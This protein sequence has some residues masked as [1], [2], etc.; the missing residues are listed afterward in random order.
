MKKIYLIIFAM[1]PLLFTSCLKSNLDEIQVYQEANITSI[2]GMYYY[3]DLKT[4]N[5]GNTIF[6]KAD[7]SRADVQIDT[8][9]GNI[10]IGRATPAKANIASF[11]PQKVVMAFNISTAA[12]IEPVE[13][14]AQL[15]VESDWS[16]GKTNKYKVTAADGSSK[17]WSVTVLS[18]ITE[19]E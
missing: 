3:F 11:S 16:V 12:T 4:T 15:G 17:I 10:V 13:G 8:E 9:A 6:S 2:R 19:A 5:D 18:Y 7:I 14:S 1:L